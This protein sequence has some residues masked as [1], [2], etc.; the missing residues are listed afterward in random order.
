MET[1]MSEQIFPSWWGP[2]GGDPI[3][4][5]NPQEI[6]AGWIAHRGR[7][8]VLIGQWVPAASQARSR[9][10]LSRKRRAALIAIAA[11]E[12]AGHAAH[13]RRVDLIAVI[14]AKRAA[15]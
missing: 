6:G 3:Q 11:A 5:R 15:G 7:Y 8:D 10:G 13:A 1:A 9:P 12:G 4:C 14:R 2:K